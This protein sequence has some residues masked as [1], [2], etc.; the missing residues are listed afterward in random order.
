MKDIKKSCLI[1]QI[2]TGLVI[3][4]ALNWGL[5]AFFNL[6]LVTRFVGDMTTTA[7]V[8]YG[9]IG[10][11]GIMKLLSCFKDCPACKK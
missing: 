10:I 2:V 3:I 8:V 9:A 11:A 4:G 6:N 1:C 7:K 5:V